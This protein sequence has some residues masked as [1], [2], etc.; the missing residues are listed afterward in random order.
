MD[1]MNQR[2][3]SNLFLRNLRVAAS[4]EDDAGPLLSGHH[5]LKHLP[6]L[7]RDVQRRRITSVERDDELVVNSFHR[8]IR[9]D[10]ILPGG[11]LTLAGFRIEPVT[12]Q[13]ERFPKLFAGNVQ[14]LPDHVEMLHGE[15]LVRF[16]KHADRYVAALYGRRHGAELH[17]QAFLEIAG[18][19]PDRVQALDESK[20]IL[21]VRKSGRKPGIEGKIVH[22][23]F[24]GAAQVAVLVDRTD[25]LLGNDCPLFREV[26]QRKL[27]PKMLDQRL[28]GRNGQFPVLF[29]AVVD[30]RLVAVHV[31]GIVEQF[32]PVVLLVEVPLAFRLGRLLRN[33]LRG[34]GSL[35]RCVFQQGILFHL[36]LDALFECKR[37]QL[38]QLDILYLLR[39]QLLLEPLCLLEIQHDRAYCI[40]GASNVFSG[41]EGSLPRCS[42]DTPYMLYSKYSA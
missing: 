26:L 39:R 10:V 40:K 12:D 2:A 19:D 3:D 9:R 22:D 25:D 36:C 30:A 37:R 35:G 15:R 1:W 14:L 18:G 28:C 41:R 5:I 4:T 38:Q 20:H 32:A 13:V 27:L 33:I 17:Q 31:L 29:P 23:G 8:K 16:R 34:F 21:D 11:E 24:E 42:P 7:P 6:V